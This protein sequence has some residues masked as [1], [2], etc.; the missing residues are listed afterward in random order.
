MFLQK[1]TLSTPGVGV[2]AHTG[3]DKPLRASSVEEPS[4]TEMISSNYLDPLEARDTP[5]KIK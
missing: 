1:P 5:K 4:T 2:A 3:F